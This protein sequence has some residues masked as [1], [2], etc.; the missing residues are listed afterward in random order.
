MKGGRL[1]C[2]HYRPKCQQR[3]SMV[4]SVGWKALV[5]GPVAGTG[6]NALET[7]PALP[8]TPCNPAE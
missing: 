7:P 6:N 2:T 1:Q 3:P 5:K 4:L 8:V